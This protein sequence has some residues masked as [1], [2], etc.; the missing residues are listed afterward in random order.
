MQGQVEGADFVVG[1]LEPLEHTLAASSTKKLAPAGPVTARPGDPG[2]VLEL[3]AG[4]TLRGR[5]IDG[6]GQPC[7]GMLV[8]SSADPPFLSVAIKPSS[9]FTAEGLAPGRYDLVGRHPDG[10]VGRLT[11]IEVDAGTVQGDLRLRL[12]PGAKLRVRY[13]GPSEYAQYRLT[14]EGVV[15]G[16]NGLRSGTTELEVVPAGTVTVV[17]RYGGEV[18]AER[19]VFCPLGEETEAAF[20]LE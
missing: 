5:Y 7:E 2:V 9:E 4:G 16:A 15:V 8:L 1:P 6:S 12:E 10:L 13:S 20:E 11:G 17:V 14:H 19:E 18:V 3:K